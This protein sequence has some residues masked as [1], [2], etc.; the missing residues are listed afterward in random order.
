MIVVLTVIVLTFVIV[1]FKELMHLTF[2]EQGTRLS[3]VPVFAFEVAFNLVLA[4]AVV[5]SIKIVGTLLISALLII[6]AASAMQLSKSFKGT[7]LVSVTLGIAT[8]LAGLVISY[9]YDLATGGAIVLFGIGV[10]ILC[11]ALKKAV[12][13]IGSAN[14]VEAR[15]GST[16]KALPDTDLHPVHQENKLSESPPGPG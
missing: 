5:V 9:I 7:V 2:D 3:G 15:T 13:W 4:F 1:F 12:R 10:F 8:V 16:A 6:P 14:P 11:V